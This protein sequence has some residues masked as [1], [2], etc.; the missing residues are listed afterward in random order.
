MLGIVI[1]TVKNDAVHDT[2]IL[3]GGGGIMAQHAEEGDPDD[4]YN[5][6]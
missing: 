3:E 4:N 1:L 2:V 5:Q 6:N